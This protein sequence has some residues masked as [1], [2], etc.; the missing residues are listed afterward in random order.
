MDYMKMYDMVR[1][2]LVRLVRMGR[3]SLD[4]CRTSLQSVRNGSPDGLAV[5]AYSAV[6]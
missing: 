2:P 1:E 6:T 4:Q 3:I 5:A